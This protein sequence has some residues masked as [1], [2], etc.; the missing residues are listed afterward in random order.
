VKDVSK[1]GGVSV[2]EKH[3]ST[4]L[5]KEAELQAQIPEE[6]KLSVTPQLKRKMT[7]NLQTNDTRSVRITGCDILL[8]GKLVFIDQEGKRLLMFSNN[9]N[10]EKDIVRISGIPYEV[11]YT[12]KHCS[13]YNLRQTRSRFCKR[14]Y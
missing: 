12:G 4:L 13:C 5:V 11:S 9:G 6:N 2:T 1:F 8:D 7:V 10:Y 3:C 14:H